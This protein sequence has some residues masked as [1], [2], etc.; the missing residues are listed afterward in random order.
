MS[1][2]GDA[3]K[4]LEFHYV[5]DCPCGT[6]LTGDTEDDIVDVS[7]AHLREKHPDMADDYERDHIL[8]MARRVVKR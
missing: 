1:P 2:D 8:F 7:F 4:E 3:P 5:L 6:T